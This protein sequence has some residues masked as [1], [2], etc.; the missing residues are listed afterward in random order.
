MFE[1]IRKNRISLIIRIT[2]LVWIL[3][4]WMSYKLWVSERL[5]PLIPPFDFLEGFTADVHLGLFYAALS[6]IFLIFLF[7]QSRLILL[8]TIT[9][10]FSSCLLD[11]NRWQPWEYQYIITVLFAFFYRSNPKQFLN[12]F[13]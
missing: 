10:E 7:P 4:K 1:V 3:T 12:Y 11:Q 6:G 13:T 5:F 2:C 8:L 9:I